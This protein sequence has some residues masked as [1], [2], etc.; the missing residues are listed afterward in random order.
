MSNAFNGEYGPYS[1]NVT[2]TQ[3]IKSL[4]NY[5]IL[6]L[7][8]E[9]SKKDYEDIITNCSTPDKIE[10]LVQGSVELMKS[11]YRILSESELEKNYENYLIDRKNNRYPIHKSISGE[12]I[13]IFNDSELSFLKEINHLKNLGFCNFAIDGRYKDE[14]HYKIIDVYKKALDGNISEKELLKYSPKNTLGNY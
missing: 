12:E 13:I 14:N 1:M 7:S 5:R 10:I 4:E 9:L 3:T 6:T 8:P 11:R 2:N